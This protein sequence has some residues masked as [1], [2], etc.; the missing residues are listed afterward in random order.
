MPSPL[1]TQRKKSLTGLTKKDVVVS[2]GCVV[3]L[4]ANIGAIGSGGR[5]R[6]KE[7]VCMSN[8]R[9]W[10]VCFQMFAND[11]DGCFPPGNPG[12]RD[13]SLSWVYMLQPY[14]KD[15]MLKMCPEATRPYKGDGTS[16]F[17]A[18][19]PLWGPGV[20]E[21]GPRTDSGDPWEAEFP[22]EDYGFSYT[23]TDRYV[24]Y[25]QNDWA[26]SVLGTGRRA[27]RRW[28]SPN[29]KGADNIPLFFDIKQF[30]VCEPDDDHEPPEYEG[31]P[32]SWPEPMKL[33]CINRHNGAINGVFFDWS[34]RKIG[35][36]CLWTLKWHRLFNNV[37]GTWVTRPGYIPA[38]PEWMGR[39]R[40][41]D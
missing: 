2:L 1:E 22:P 13:P 37:Y 24:S 18:F 3:F 40:E 29:V 38:W 26:R 14:Y 17:K 41:C 34:V 25:A 12:G 16:A 8:L 28:K 21:Y 5:K 30:Y 31:E 39:L 32:G 7:A 9:K 11:D 23:D 27:D 6:A 10:G 36:K 33:V 15:G 19:G 4:L 35:L 20:D